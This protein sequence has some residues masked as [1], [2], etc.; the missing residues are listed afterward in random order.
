MTIPRSAVLFGLTLG[1]LAAPLA[2]NGQ[3][4][5]KVYRIGLLEVV[6]IVSNAANLT[7]F[8]QGLGQL[9][10]VEGQNLVIEYRSAGGQAERFP[11]LAIELVRLNMDV[12]VTSPR[13]CL[14]RQDPQG[15]EAGRPAD[16]TA[17]QAGAGHQPQGGEGARPQDPAVG[18][19]PNGRADPVTECAVIPEGA[20]HFH[21]NRDTTGGSRP[22][23]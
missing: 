11:D 13:S 16:R 17:D 19:G 2:A 5:G 9:G 3:Q 12:I 1:L 4:T 6:P 18:A 14:C 8:Q 21:Q 7:A 23:V 20:A 15:R 22:M 10:Y